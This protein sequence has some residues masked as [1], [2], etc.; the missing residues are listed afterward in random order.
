M[1]KDKATKDEAEEKD[2]KAGARALGDE[3]VDEVTWPGPS[4]SADP[5]GSDP[6]DTGVEPEPEAPEEPAARK[7][8]R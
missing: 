7:E 4:A 3:P 8:E 5:N 2:S 1:S 6:V